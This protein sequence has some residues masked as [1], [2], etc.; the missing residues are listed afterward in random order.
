M[1]AAKFETIQIPIIP[2][3]NIKHFMDAWTESF[4]I[5]RGIMV[6]FR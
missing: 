6:F 4:C 2:L 5:Y 1:M 3:E